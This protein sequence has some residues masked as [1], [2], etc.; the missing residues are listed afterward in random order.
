MRFLV[1]LSAA[2][3][4][5]VPAGGKPLVEAHRAAAGNFPENSRAAVLAAVAA[6]YPG[7]EIDLVLTEDKVP[8]LSHDAWINEVTCTTASGEKLGD[9][10]LFIK[11]FTLAELRAGFLCGV[12]REPENPEA[13]LVPETHMSYDEFI[14]AIRDGPD[15]M[16]VHLDIKYEPDGTTLPLQDFVD[17][18]IPPWKAA[19]LPNPWYVST[20]LPEVIRAFEAAGGVESSLAWPRFPPGSN[21]TFVALEKELWTSLGF[22]HIVATARA[23]GADGLAIP[24]QVA[25]RH[26]IEGARRQ[27]LKVQIWTLNSRALLETYCG[28]PIEAVITDYPERAPCL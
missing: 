6:G 17:A 3:C 11:D 7:I 14:A 13:Q 12:A 26:A 16:V 21:S 10:R 25:D 28:W 15:T 20:N 23:A 5:F 18:I 27:G 19:A 24:Y 9:E 2:A 8:V 22:E 4:G 1:A